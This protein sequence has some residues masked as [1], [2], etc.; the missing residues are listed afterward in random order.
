MPRNF[1]KY[2][3]IYFIAKN[4]F[5]LFFQKLKRSEKQQLTKN[6]IAKQ[7]VQKKTELCVCVY[8]R[9]RCLVDSRKQMSEFVLV[10]LVAHFLIHF[11]AMLVL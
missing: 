2:M 8:V 11:L 10:A 7:Q 9:L 5:Y 6:I 1:V 4:F 3:W